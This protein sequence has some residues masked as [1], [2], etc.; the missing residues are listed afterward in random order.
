MKLKINF[1]NY[2]S[3]KSIKMKKLFLTSVLAVL[4]VA[5][6][7]KKEETSDRETQN[8]ATTEKGK[9]AGKNR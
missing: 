9:C 5:S 3:L 8:Y 1:N 6:C 7:S 4:T 2:S